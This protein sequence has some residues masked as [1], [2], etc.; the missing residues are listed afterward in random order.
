VLANHNH[1]SLTSRRRSHPNPFAAHWR[2]AYP[3]FVTLALTL[4]GLR[5][6]LG[7]FQTMVPPQWIDVWVFLTVG[8]LIWQVIGTM[9]AADRFLKYTGN[10]LGLCA[11]YFLLLVTAVLTFVQTADALAAKHEFPPF[12][13]SSLRTLPV[14]SKDGVMRVDGNLDWELFGAFEHTLDSYP[15]IQSVRLGST[16]GY[17]FVARAMAAKILERSLDT[18]VA[19]HCYS[20]CA[21]AFLAGERRTMAESAKLGFH[22]YKLEAGHQPEVINVADELE[23]DR[24]FFT[25]RGLSDEFVQQVFTAAHSDLWIPDSELLIK[26][27]VIVN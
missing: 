3:L 19:T 7:L 27:G 4:V 21:V 9:R 17:V 6:F 16:G 1:R 25:R 20:A 22:K 12:D 13:I 2:G 5:V 23:K 14:M 15:D 26:S 11:A 24:Q 8:V 18:H 10:V